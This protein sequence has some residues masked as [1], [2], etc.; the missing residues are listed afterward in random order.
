MKFAVFLSQLL[1]SWTSRSPL[2]E[3]VRVQF[4]ISPTYLH[5][6]TLSFKTLHIRGGS[7]GYSEDQ[8]KGFIADILEDWKSRIDEKRL[9]DPEYDLRKEYEEL[10][11]LISSFSSSVDNIDQTVA[12]ICFEK[13][14]NCFEESISK[15]IERTDAEV[16]FAHMNIGIIHVQNENNDKA[17]YYFKEAVETYKSCFDETKLALMLREMGKI[18]CGKDQPEE[19]IECFLSAHEMNDK[20]LKGPNL[21]VTDESDYKINNAVIDEY[22]GCIY[23]SQG[24]QEKALACHR[25]A[26]STWL[27]HA[28]EINDDAHNVTQC[29]FNIGKCY[30]EMG[31]P[32]EAL[33]NYNMAIEKI[34]PKTENKITHAKLLARIC[35]S[36]GVAFYKL[37][38]FGQSEKYYLHSIDIRKTSFG[39]D[40][41][42]LAQTYKHLGITLMDKRNPELTRSRE[43]FLKALQIYQSLYGE[44]HETCASVYSRI[45]STFMLNGN[46]ELCMKNYLKAFEIYKEKYGEDHVK[47]TEMLLNIG[48]AYYSIKKDFPTAIEYYIKAITIHKRVDEEEIDYQS[49]GE[50][51][52]NVAN[53]YL[54]MKRYK[55]AY[56]YFFQCRNI[57]EKCSPE[58]QDSLLQ[59][60]QFLAQLK[61]YLDEDE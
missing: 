20:L 24:K 30:T 4:S 36:I 10:R 58:D 42:S 45:G 55:D 16:A 2:C 15:K 25:K 51:Y 47:I 49:L 37:G 11:L 53:A 3:A 34:G 59:L 39:E 17:L 60:N 19:A 48:G 50:L 28:H 41:T 56:E 7:N 8:A 61:H 29:Y 21:S 6:K 9:L 54:E 33:K 23:N 14:I 38:E 1:L 46:F 57:H 13:A 44:M 26:L 32:Q 22:L 5:T 18:Y 43:Y 12:D 52:A 35:C 27:D 31:Q 40:Q